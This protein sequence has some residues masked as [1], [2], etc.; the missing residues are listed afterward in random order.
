MSKRRRF[1]R[2]RRRRGR[3]R[4]RGRRKKRQTLVIRQWQPDVVRFCKINGW[5][6]LI[7]CGSGSTQNNFIVHSEDITP[8]GAPYGGNLTHITWCL[9]AIYQ[10][11]LMHRNRWT[12]SNHDLD[13]MRYLGVRFKAY[14]H[15]TTDYIISYSRTSPFQVTE[16]SYLS[17]HPLLMLLSK[18]HIVVKSL[19]TKPRGKPYVKFFCKPPKLMLNKWYFTKDFAKVP[20]LMMW[21]TACELRNPW[22]REGTLSPCIGFYA[23]KPS[24]YT[25]LSILPEKVKQF[26]TGQNSDTITQSGYYSVVHPST[27]NTTQMNWQYTYTPLMQ[28][29]FKAANGNEPYNW[30]TYS[31]PNKYSSTYTN[32]TTARDTKWKFYQK[33][34][35][36]VY[37]TLTTQSPTNFFLFQEFGIYSPYYITPQR[38]DIDWNTPYTYTRYNPLADKGLGN[39]IWVDWCSRDEATYDSTRSKCMLKDLP[40]FIMFYGYIDWVQKS[41]GSQTITR[42]MRVMVICPYTEPQLVDPQDK[43]KGFVIYGDTFA[44]GNMPVLAPQIPISWFVRWYPNLAH[45]RETLESVVSCG[46]F[47]VR[48]QEKN[49]WDITLGYHFLFK[50]GGSPLPSQAIDDPSQKPTHALPEPGTLPRILQVSDPAR[51]GPKTIFHQWDQRRGLFTKRSI[52]R[53]SEYSSDDENFS[54]GPSKRPALDTRPEGL[55]GEQRSAYAFLRALQDSQD[56]EESQE[57]APLLEEQA[58]QKEKEELLLKQ[59][60]QQRQ[61][62]RVLKRG[63]RVLFG[64]VLKLRRGLHIDPLLT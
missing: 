38:R 23:L 53:M 63:L 3:R 56:S 9:E 50:W 43:T 15:P 62:Q 2:R 61:H 34:Y 21:A 27:I 59:L 42:D 26:A 7:V 13:L 44:N 36:K 45:Q 4:Y 24:I 33:E 64:D 11:F 30:D 58:H 57:E 48:D 6:P 55:A 12:R 17:C 39:M 20:I 35:N 25:S 47:M 41:I 60:Q 8:R 54:P 10:E 22:L 14:R 19:Q 16:L 32:F 51:L 1:R 5:L 28:S 31:T 40:L 18:H 29:F 49:S 37:P 52:K 46:P